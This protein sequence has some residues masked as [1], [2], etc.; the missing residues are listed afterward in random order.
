MTDCSSCFEPSAIIALDYAQDAAKSKKHCADCRKL[1][2][3]VVTGFLFES[4][5]GA[6]KVLGSSNF[7]LSVSLMVIR[8]SAYLQA[9]D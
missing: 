2:V 3:E 6:Y 8:K 1:V 5:E 7:T 9:E 4:R